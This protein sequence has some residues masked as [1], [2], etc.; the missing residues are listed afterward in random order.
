MLDLSP[1]PVVATHSGCRKL[2]NH[3]RN[4]SPQLI[5]KI[6]ATGGLIGIP[7]VHKFIG[8]RPSCVIDHVEEVIQLVGPKHVSVGSDLDGAKLIPGIKDV[9]SW[10]SVVID[11]L[12][13]RGYSQ[14]VINMVAGGNALRVFGEAEKV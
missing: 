10:S 8:D 2:V 9:S 6:A 13:N 12:A 11:G 5:K 1:H 14:E 3:P 7:F 4:L